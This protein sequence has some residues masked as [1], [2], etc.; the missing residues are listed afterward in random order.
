DIYEVSQENESWEN[1]LNNGLIEYID[2]EEEE[3]IMCAM[4]ILDLNDTD[5]QNIYTH[6]EIHPA[7]MLGICGSIIPF[8]DHN[9]SPRNTY[10]SAMGKQAMGVYATNYLNRFDTQ[11]HVMFYPQ[12]PLVCTKSM[13]Y[14][15]F[16]ELPAGQNVIV[17]IACYSGYNQEDSIII[18]SSSIDRGLFRSSFFRSYSEEESQKNIYKKERFEKPL[19]NT[20]E[21]LKHGTYDKIDFDGLI[22]PGIRVSGNDI[23]IGKTT[24][25]TDTFSN[26]KTNERKKDKKCSS[27]PLRASESGVIDQVVL[28]T[29]EENK[30]FVKVRVRSV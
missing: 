28:T 27:V 1:F 8:P 11:S 5:R 15:K 26:T 25:I 20:C 30:K 6:C 23:I 3:T 17:A 4:N 16:R 24:P 2:N 9:Q 12:K 22:S 18:N 21:G 29:N 7:M 13:E 19:P 14:L 10:Q